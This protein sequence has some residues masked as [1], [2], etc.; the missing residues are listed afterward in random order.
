MGLGC[1]WGLWGVGCPWGLWWLGWPGGGL[2]GHETWLVKSRD[3]LITIVLLVLNCHKGAGDWNNILL[4]LPW[5]CSCCGY[6]PDVVAAMV[7][8]LMLG[9]FVSHY[10]TIW[11]FI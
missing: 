9:C 3:M 10:L 6:R 7:T 4:W 11:Q 1:P 5:C 8:S 2:A